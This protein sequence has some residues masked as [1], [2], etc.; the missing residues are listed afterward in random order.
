MEVATS[1][2]LLDFQ[3]LAIGL[4]HSAAFMFTSNTVIEDAR[5]IFAKNTID[6]EFDLLIMIDDDISLSTDL[7]D[8]FIQHPFDVLGAF[9]PRRAIDLNLFHAAGADGKSFEDA[10]RTA[11]PLIGKPLDDNDTLAEPGIRL[12]KYLG[13]GVM[14]IKRTALETLIEKDATKLRYR[15][16]KADGETV[17]GFFDQ[18]L[19]SDGTRFSEDF[20]FCH[21]WGHRRIWS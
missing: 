8:M 4:G 19:S 6:G 17:Y 15:N 18:L 16:R 12:A 10:W 11:A 21:R 20:S 13:G 14:S 1:Q 5:N 2:T 9:C 3:R 7:C